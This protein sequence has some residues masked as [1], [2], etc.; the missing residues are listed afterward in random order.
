[1]HRVHVEA[2]HALD[3][4][5]HAEGC[6]ALHAVGAEGTVMPTG[7]HHDLGLHHVR[8]HATLRPPLV[9]VRRRRLIQAMWLGVHLGVVIE[10]DEGP[11]GDDAAD[12]G[13]ARLSILADDEVLHHSCVEQLHVG[14]G[15]DLRMEARRGGV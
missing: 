2:A 7:R 1:M 4:R 10:C 12:A 13:L 3:G 11:V 14:L 8:V 15:Q 6:K 5:K 9:S